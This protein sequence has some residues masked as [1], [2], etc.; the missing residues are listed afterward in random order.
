MN[1]SYLRQQ[2]SFDPL[3]LGR[4]SRSVESRKNDTKSIVC[5][6]CV[7]RSVNGIRKVNY[8]HVEC[9]LH[10]YGIPASEVRPPFDA[11]PR[12]TGAFETSTGGWNIDKVQRDGCALAP[13]MFRPW[14]V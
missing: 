6:G 8:W 5:R 11:F 13:R 7:I 4:R 3:Q 12:P 2:G 9:S 14:E 10:D 1:P